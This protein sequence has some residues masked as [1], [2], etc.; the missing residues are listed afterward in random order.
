MNPA[1]DAFV[2]TEMSRMLLWDLR[3]PALQGSCMFNITEKI[4]GKV[5]YDP[6]GTVLAL[7]FSAGNCSQ[8]KLFN[9]SKVTM[10]AIK[11]WDIPAPTITSIQFSDNGLYILA[12]TNRAQLFV[13][14]AFQGGLL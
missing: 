4:K 12:M 9:T 11:T 1:N 8:L 2:S 5:A 7:V 14:N 6:T 3:S 13:I 10:G